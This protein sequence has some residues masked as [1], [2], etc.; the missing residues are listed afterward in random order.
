MCW[1]GIVEEC[2]EAT[3]FDVGYGALRCFPGE[4][5][6]RVAHRGHAEAKK[7]IYVYRRPSNGYAW[8]V[9][10]TEMAGWTVR[11]RLR[12]RPSPGRVG[13]S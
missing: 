11:T 1:V 2:F 4:N 8:R 7:C 5:E 9:R 6:T 13:R 3:L 10:G 12:R